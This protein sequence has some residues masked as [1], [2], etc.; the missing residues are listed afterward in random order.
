MY[1]LLCTKTAVA[2]AQAVVIGIPKGEKMIK[3][4]AQVQTAP[5]R[6]SQLAYWISQIGSPP[7]TGALTAVMIGFTLSTPPG[8]RWTLF[9]ITLTIL[10]PC[11]YIIWLVRSGKAVDF[12]LPNRE[13]RIRPLQF[14]V[15]TALIAW[16]VL[17]EVQAPRMLQLL[18]TVTLIQSALFLII[19]MYWKISL[20]CTAA[21]I[22]SELAFVLFGASAAPLTVSIPLIA[23]SRVHL[24]RHTVAQTIAG[25]F[26]G[27]LIVTP[28]IFMYW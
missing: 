16:L 3:D 23:W 25:I 2:F 22:L 20:H 27:V 1:L 15:I 21:T 26:L 10:A 5:P 13:Q 14:S 8:W 28:T 7:L 12:H 9:Y 18:A 11:F 19:T 17:Y 24:E 4:L 6:L